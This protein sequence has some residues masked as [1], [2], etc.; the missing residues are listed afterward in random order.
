MLNK[1]FTRDKDKYVTNTFNIMMMTGY[2]FY[3]NDDVLLLK[4]SFKWKSG[5]GR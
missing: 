4:Q 1:T 2:F 5:R 3:L